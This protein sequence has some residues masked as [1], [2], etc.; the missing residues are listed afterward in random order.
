MAAGISFVSLKMD[1]LLPVVVI[2][3]TTFIFS[4]WGVYLGKKCGYILKSKAEIVGGVIL[5]GIG[6]KI[7]ISHLME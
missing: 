2:G 1:I 6:L 4:Y 7:L 5:V 3:I